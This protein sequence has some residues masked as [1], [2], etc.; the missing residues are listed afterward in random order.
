[1]IGKLRGKIDS[2]EQDYLILDVGGVGY[3]IYASAQTLRQMPPE[4]EVIS[5]SIET[6]VREDHIHLYGFANPAEQK[7]FKILTTVK[8]VGTRMALSVLS[9]LAP[10]QLNTAIAA[11]DKAAFKSVN[12]VGPKLADRLLT[13]LKDQVGTIASGEVALAALSSSTTIDSTGGVVENSNDK[14]VSDAVSALTN[15][16]YSRSDAYQTVTRLMADQEGEAKV[17][18]IIRKS[19]RELAV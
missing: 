6:H 19:L 1:V 13:E 5:M 4:G 16:G 14:A 10:E 17:E 15:L 7:W 18:D 8:G 2:I 3:I 9:V 12:G 11:Q